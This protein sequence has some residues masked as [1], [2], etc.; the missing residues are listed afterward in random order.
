[1]VHYVGRFEDGDDFDSSFKRNRPFTFEIQ[2][3]KVIRCWDDGFLH[4]TKGMRARLLCPPDYAYGSSGAGRVIP[5]DSD[6]MFDVEL[7][8]IN[9][10]EVVE[11]RDDEG[12]RRNKRNSWKDLPPIGDDR[13]H[14]C[15]SPEPVYILGATLIVSLAYLVYA[16]MLPVENISRS[17]RLQLMSEKKK[18][19]KKIGDSKI[20]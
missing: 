4:L 17:K 9:P 13:S 12:L 11:P 3:N 20:E 19:S 10:P 16:C 8:D 15:L 2:K 5:P 1:M 6:L 7:L 14:V 18:R